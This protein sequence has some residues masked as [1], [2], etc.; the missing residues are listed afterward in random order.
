MP[1]E[2]RE[3]GS[4][5]TQLEV[6]SKDLRIGYIGKTMGNIITEAQ[7][8]WTIAVNKGPPGFQD[9]GHSPTF[10]DAKA[11]VENNWALWCEAAGLKE[12]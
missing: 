7:W 9:N 1:L 4:S 11:H 2:Y 6:F 5:K 8:R 12:G 3:R 10:E